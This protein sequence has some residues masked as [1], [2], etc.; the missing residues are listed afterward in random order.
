MCRTGRAGLQD[1]QGLEIEKQ[2]HARAVEDKA[3]ADC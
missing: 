3:R 1:L 2:G